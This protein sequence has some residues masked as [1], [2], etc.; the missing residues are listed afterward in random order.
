[1]AEQRPGRGFWLWLLT[2]GLSLGP[3]RGLAETARALNEAEELTP[4]LAE[5]VPAWEPYVALCWILVATVFAAAWY[6]VY[7]IAA[8]THRGQIHQLV[9]LLWYAGFGVTLL[10]T[11]ATAVLF[12][13]EA[14]QTT[15]SDPAY[16]GAVIGS[17]ISPSLWTAY[18]LLSKRVAERYPSLQ[19]PRN[20]IVDYF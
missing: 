12:G 19:D 8:G 4:N 13:L 15:L 10:D 16:V 2:V 1:M 18:L 11:L 5:L 9:G 6:G 3:F 17:V 7:L 14:L 20:A